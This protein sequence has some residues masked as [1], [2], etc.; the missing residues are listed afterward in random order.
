MAIQGDGSGYISHVAINTSGDFRLVAPP[1]MTYR[2][3]KCINR[4]SSNGSTGL[5]FTT[6][7]GIE[8]LVAGT[9]IATITIP[10]ISEN[11][12][13]E[14][15]EVV[16]SGTTI[17]LSANGV[18]NSGESSG[19][20]L[21]QNWFGHTGQAYNYDGI[22]QGVAATYQNGVLQK[23]FDFNE[24]DSNQTTTRNVAD[25]ED[26]GT[27]NDFT[28]GGFVANSL[29]GGSTTPAT[30]STIIIDTENN[31]PTGNYDVVVINA[32]GDTC[33]TFANT[34][35]TSGSARV[36]L[37]ITEYPIGATV[38]V[39]FMDSANELSYF[40]LLTTIATPE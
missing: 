8:F 35:F 6:G 5:F 9:A 38:Q 24:T 12:I 40:S 19:T 21:L 20:V 28:T 16:R 27:F 17:T 29:T 32:A 18:S 2:A 11:D 37:D 26:T 14:N 30:T 36:D 4:R 31:L 33:E 15:L 3:E 39:G 22:A 10:N 34:V 23:E 1:L 13:V 7:G 25:S